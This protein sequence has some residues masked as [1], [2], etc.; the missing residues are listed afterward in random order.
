MRQFLMLSLGLCVL[1]VL[2]AQAQIPRMVS[3]QGVVADSAGA[4]I[5]DGA[6]AITF[7]LYSAASGGTALWQEPK[8]MQL[9]RGLIST[10]LGDQVLFGASVDF[11]QPYWLGIQIGTDPEMQPRVRFTSSGYSIRAGKADTSLFALTAPTPA[12]VDSARIAGSIPN[13]AVTTAELADGAVT[14]AK[15]LN[16]TIQR[17]DAFQFGP[18]ADTRLGAEASGWALSERH[19]TAG[20]SFVNDRCAAFVRHTNILRTCITTKVRSNINT[21][22]SLFIEKEPAR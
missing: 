2:P 14:S 5:P 7:R 12:V 6:Y 10:T 8:T 16:G 4:P 9:H 21:G 20:I 22:E 18:R 15:I 3:Y 19:T 1:T 11:S 17:L 13:N